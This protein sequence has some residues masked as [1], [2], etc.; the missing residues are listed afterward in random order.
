MLED[1]IGY[2]YSTSSANKRLFADQAERFED[3]LRCGL[4]QMEPSGV[5]NVS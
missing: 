3:E 2:L 4:L 1:A 5:S